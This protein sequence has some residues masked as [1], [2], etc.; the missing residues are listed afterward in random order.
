ME[1]AREGC[2]PPLA[3]LPTSLGPGQTVGRMDFGGHSS[4]GRAEQKT[5]TSM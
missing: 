4:R 3:G 5:E 2:H 1:K